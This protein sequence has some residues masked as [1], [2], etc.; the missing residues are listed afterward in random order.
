[1]A[2]QRPNVF[3]TYELTEK[4]SITGS[5]LNLD[6]KRVIQNQLAAVAEQ[7]LGLTFDPANPG[8]FIQDD[9]HLKG[10]MAAFKLLLLLSE[11]AEQRLNNQA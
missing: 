1:M 11:D 2:V 7:I 4:E 10:Q 3:T 5:F 6:Q 9:A 8:T